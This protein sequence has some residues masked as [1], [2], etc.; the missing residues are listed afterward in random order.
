M[1]PAIFAQTAI[2]ILCPCGIQIE[3]RDKDWL[4]TKKMNAFLSVA[5]GSCEPPVFLE[6]GYCG[7]SVDEKPIVLIG[8]RDSNI[9]SFLKATHC[10]NVLLFHPLV[11]GKGV[12]FDTGGLCLSSPRGMDEMRADMAGAAVVVGV[13]KAAASMSLPLNIRGKWNDEKYI[14]VV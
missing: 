7:G 14:L 12:T 3:V 5:R 9:M 11:I 8:T 1:T 13:L 6:L 10:Y 4:E 2:D